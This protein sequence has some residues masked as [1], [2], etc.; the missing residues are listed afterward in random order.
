MNKIN[1]QQR[2]F[3][4]VLAEQRSSNIVPK[5]EIKNGNIKN[6]LKENINKNQ[7][8]YQLKI[9]NNYPSDQKINVKKYLFKIPNNSNNSNNKKHYI[10]KDI[11]N[12]ELKANFCSK[13]NHQNIRKLNGIR[14]NSCKLNGHENNLYIERKKNFRR[15]NPDITDPELLMMVNP[16]KIRDNLLFLFLH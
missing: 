11:Y 9:D 16:I 6:A 4:E 13:I 8:Q 14:P 2:N 15:Y 12:N 10:K 5:R 3:K 7:N 1:I